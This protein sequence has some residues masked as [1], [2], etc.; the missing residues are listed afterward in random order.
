MTMTLTSTPQPARNIDSMPYAVDAKMCNKGRRF[1]ATKRRLEFHFGFGN[2]EA[3][4]NGLAASECRGEEHQVVMIWSLTSGKQRVLADGIEVHFSRRSVTD[5]FECQWTMKSGH[6][7][8]VVSSW[9]P[10]AKNV[11]SFDLRIDGLSF[12]DMPKIYQ[13]GGGLKG[14]SSAPRRRAVATLDSNSPCSSTSTCCS[15]SDSNSQ[16]GQ[17][18]VQYPSP[19][20]RALSA[21]ET[22]PYSVTAVWDDRLSMSTHKQPMMPQNPFAGQ[23]SPMEIALRSL[24][25][26]DAA[27]YSPVRPSISRSPSISDLSVQSAYTP[28]H[29]TLDN[30]NYHAHSLSYSFSNSYE[31]PAPQWQPQHTVYSFAG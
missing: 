21:P 16:C 28:Q 20:Q 22:S 26:M 6:Q 8:T 1:A 19:V 23:L 12:W 31:W 27:P 13:L 3:I 15:L 2:K 14:P 30:F 17:V 9:A 10:L 18:P 25:N 29:H 24:V 11:R 7:I 5:K 4:E